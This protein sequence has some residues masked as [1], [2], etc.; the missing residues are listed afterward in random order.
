MFRW[1]VLLAMV[2]STSFA[3]PPP[4][5]KVEGGLLA[6]KQDGATSA[7][8]GIPYAAPPVGIN[9]WRAPQHAPAW[10]GVRPSSEFGA[11]C[12]QAG[13]VGARAALFSQ[14]AAYRPQPAVSEDCLFLNVW[15]PAAAPG[16]RLPVLVFFHGGGW[17]RG[18]GSESS[19]AGAPMASQGVVMVTA[20]FRLGL[21]GFLA[22]QALL[23][24]AGDTGNY[25]LMDQ[26]AVLNWV[27]RNIAAFGGDPN[28]VT[29]AGQSA[30]AA[31]VRFMM[32]IPATDGLFKRAIAESTPF[33]GAGPISLNEALARGAAFADL[34]HA[35]TLSELRAMSAK[36]L[37]ALAPPG[38]PRTNA[39]GFLPV[40]GDRLLPAGAKEREDVAMIAGTNTDDIGVDG[41]EW[42]VS[43]DAGLQ[44]VLNKHFKDYAPK[45]AVFYRPALYGG[46]ATDAARAIISDGPAAEL[47]LAE[48]GRSPN[49]APVYTYLWTHARPGDFGAVHSSE[50]AYVYQNL[51]LAGGPNLSEQDY[52]ISKEINNYW[53][54]FIKTGNPNG[55]TLPY[56]PEARSGETM[57]LG[58]HF[59][60]STRLTSS[61]LETYQDYAAHGG[62]FGL[63]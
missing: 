59:A 38:L 25:G 2:A 13:P 41:Q 5:V 35:K 30:G 45:F 33:W 51:P 27:K 19:F 47:A 11:N 39:L 22:H 37:L 60:A 55:H 62:K 28:Q 42:N 7:Y 34:A 15:T 1:A 17:N 53:V 46:S 43:D 44:Q 14:A 31:G 49:A 9:R 8:L 57:E 12:M 61:K 24:E 40:S 32:S 54:N 23:D 52:L 36:D 29:L 26:I 6:G 20:N 58:D 21:F 16:A 63:P 50:L 3:A 10:S 4:I 56:W 48:R 18:S